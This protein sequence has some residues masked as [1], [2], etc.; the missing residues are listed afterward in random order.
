MLP[1]WAI[2]LLLPVVIVPK[3]HVNEAI[4]LA[5][6]K[7]LT[8][9]NQNPE[10]AINTS[11]PRI[12]KLQFPNKV[13][14]PVFTGE[15][16]KGEGGNSI[17]I[18]LIDDLTGQVVNSGPEAFS[19]VEIVP[20]MG[21]FDGDERDNWTHEEFNDKIFRENEGKNSLLVGSVDLKLHEGIGRVGAIKFK[22]GA[23]WMKTQK[24]RLGARVVDRVTGTRVKEAKTESFLI[25]DR[26]NKLYKKHHP[27]SL[28][29]YKK[30]HSPSLLGEVWQLEKIGRYGAFHKRLIEE[31]V[32]TVKDFLTL[33]FLDPT[34]LRNILGTGMSA[35]M[36]KVT[37]D[38]ARTCEI[39]TRC[40]LYCPS[41]S[42]HKAGVVF[43]AV[44]QLMGILS[45]CQYIATDK[46]SETEKACS[47]CRKIAD[48]HN[49]VIS[50]FRNFEDVVS[51]D[52]EASLT[53]GLLP[54]SNGLYP[55]N[56]AI[57]GSSDGNKDLASEKVGKSDCMQ[58]SASSP[59]IMPS[60]YSIGGVSLDDYGLQS[61][62]SMD[63][64]EVV[65]YQPYIDGV[66]FVFV[67]RQKC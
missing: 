12:L 54:M 51:F 1:Y 39:D 22:H 31:K 34:R 66:D 2:V 25:K 33:L 14:L 64:V 24:F 11:E 4:E 58:L 49:S 18:E 20:L 43:N 59:D 32:Y 53:D 19:K 41:G 13:G 40:Y 52:D 21:D 56:S 29:V 38:H 10:R 36:W 62:D 15:E 55:S 46:L 60:I 42:Q 50:A 61:I 45:D 65:Y 48:A 8:S 6:E 28:L 63:D 35:K 17:T 16:I 30:P 37:V 67:E 7:I 9:I 5:P 47:A 23:H 3:T 26:R 57:P 44:G 27:P